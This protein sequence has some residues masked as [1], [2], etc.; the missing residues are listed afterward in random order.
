MNLAEAFDL[1]GSVAVVTGATRGLGREAALALAAAGADVAVTGRGLDRLEP[2]CDEINS[3]DKGSAK[4]Y[5]LDVNDGGAIGDVMAEVSREIGP[6]AVL[7]NNAGIEKQLLLEEM[8]PGDWQ[9]VLDTN[10]G[11]VIACSRAFLRENGERG[12][13]IINVSSIGAA[14]GV[15]GQSAYCASKGGVVSLT[16]ALAVELARRSI[17]VNA[18]APGYFATDMPAEVISD[19]AR[20]DKLLKQI[21]LRRLGEPEEIGPLVVYL[22]APASAFMTGS[23]IYLDGGFTAR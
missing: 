10:L 15:V 7:L 4:C 11:S 21:P 12:G 1:E 22:A 13:S 5:A 20:K 19:S 17:R 2:L 9:S 16:R 23:V 18:I 14:A 8:E 3:R 6:P